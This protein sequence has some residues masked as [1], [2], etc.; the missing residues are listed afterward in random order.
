M[1]KETITQIF[2]FAVIGSSGFLVDFGFYFLLS[3]VFSFG[4]IPAN[5]ISVALA[6]VWN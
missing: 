6:I 4:E 3:R 1:K 2:R 5:L